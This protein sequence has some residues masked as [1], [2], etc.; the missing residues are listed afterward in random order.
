MENGQALWLD[1]SKTSVFDFYQFC[2][3]IGDA[4]IADLLKKLTFLNLDDIDDIMKEHE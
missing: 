2:I 1:S 4:E 3:N